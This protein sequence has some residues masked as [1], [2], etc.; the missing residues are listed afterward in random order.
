MAAYLAMGASADVAKVL[1]DDDVTLA[2]VW[3]RYWSQHM[4]AMVKKLD[5]EFGVAD[6]EANHGSR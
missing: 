2:R 3:A 4:A 5:A 1:A 6:A